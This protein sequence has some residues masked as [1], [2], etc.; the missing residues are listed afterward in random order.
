M[1]P[2]PSKSA[3][4]SVRTGDYNYV[5]DFYNASGN[6][7]HSFTIHD[8]FSVTAGTSTFY[9]RGGIQEVPDTVTLY[10]CSLSLIFIP[11]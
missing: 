1:S 7:W 9:F 10:G 11:D 2:A 6:E 8:V 3:T 4:G 5:R